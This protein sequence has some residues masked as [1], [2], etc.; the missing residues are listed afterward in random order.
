MASVFGTVLGITLV[1]WINAAS[2]L[3]QNADFESTSF[4]GNWVAVDC[5]M[6]SRSD[7]TFHGAHSVMI[8]NRH[9]AWSSIRQNF[10]VSAGKNYVVSMRFKILNLPAGHN[11]T[12]VTL[13]VALTVN[14]QPKYSLL[15]N[16]PLQQLRFG[17][18]E[19]SGDFHAPTGATIASPYI[20]I[21]DTEVNFLLDAASATELNHD[22]HWLTEANQRINKLRKAPIS[23]K[24]PDGVNAHG[25]S[26]ELVQKKRAFAFGTAVG[27]TQMTDN[28]HKTYQDFVYK[29][30]EWAVLENALKWRQMEWTEGHVDYDRP[31]NAIAALRSH[32]IK[33]RGHNMFWGVDQFVPQWLSGKSQSQL[34]TTMKKH[35]HD[36][37]SRTHGKLEHWDVN[38]ED[39]HGDWY[40]RH[41][42]DP[43]IT[44]KM[45]QWIHN[46]ESQV[47]LFLNDY[48]VIT[49]SA[50]TTALRNQGQQFKR[51]GIPIYGLGI[52]GHFNSHNIDMDAVKYRLDK[53]A[54][55]G[56]KLWITELSLSDTDENRQAANLEK[57][58]TLFFSH[59]AVEGVLFWGFW[60]GKIWH[61]ENALFTGTNITANAAG[62]K[63]LDLFHKT[64]KT[65]FVH[66]I[67]PSHTVQTSGFLGEYLLNI[68]KNGH[69]IHQEN[70]SLDSS[71]KDITINLTNDHQGV[72]HVAFG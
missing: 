64:W 68:K 36:V 52:Q 69:L 17:W 7:D 71:G 47:K 53:V 70:F 46:Q 43:D 2:E 20:Q 49:S 58:M 5:T 4:S 12:K 9:H 11:Y 33:V 51:D 15:S 8:S 37:I 61:K 60:D 32:G 26:V 63:Y 65:Y 25:I 34:L 54:E 6:T 31:L 13:M 28:T 42:G 10:A 41:T 59:P 27:A 50:E 23:F 55:S 24:L 1:C 19:I 22:P 16:L 38:N 39:L 35:V 45:F 48:M 30:F 40:E 3:L 67:Q 56:L 57:V 62:Q 44:E 21:A 66:N 18:T 29:N 14:G 72:S